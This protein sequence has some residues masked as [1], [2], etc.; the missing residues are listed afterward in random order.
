MKTKR[1]SKWKSATLVALALALMP[2]SVHG[3]SQ[4][5]TVE[6]PEST[7]RT[8]TKTIQLPDKA[9]VEEMVSDNGAVSYTVNGKDATITV[10]GGSP[11]SNQYNATKYARTETTSRTS[12]TNSFPSS[13]SYNS[14][15]F[16][17]SLYP[18]GNSYQI[19]GSFTQADTIY[20][21][22]QTSSYYNSGGY[23]GT[24]SQYLYSGSYTPSDSKTVTNGASS[25]TYGDVCYPGGVLIYKSPTSLAGSKYYSSGGY[26]GTLYLN[27]WSGVHP[28]P[29]IACGVSPNITYGYRYKVDY[30]YSGTV[31]KPGSDT[32]VYRYRG[33]VTRPASDTRQYQQDYSG[34]VY[35]A[36]YDTTYRYS[37]NVNYDVD[38][39]APDAVITQTP[40]TWTNGAVTIQL[41]NIQDD[42]YSGLKHVV[43]P[44]G[45]IMNQ[46]SIAYAVTT[47]GNYDFIL[48]DNLGN[49]RTKTVSV[50]NIEKVAPTANLS[51][52]TTDWTNSNVTLNLTAI[53]DS[54]GSGYS[55]TK[56]PNGSYVTTTT[57]S[58]VV[59][60]N[61]T[62]SFVIY[63]NAGNSTTKSITVSNI[64]KTPPSGT[65]QNDSSEPLKGLLLTLITDNTGSGTDTIKKPDGTI[66]TAINASVRTSSAGEYV[67]EITDRAGNK[68]VVKSV[69]KT[70]TFSVTQDGLKYVIDVQKQYNEV[71][72]IQRIET[73]ESFV[74]ENKSYP[75]TG[76]GD[77]T[78][79][80]NDGGIW[81]ESIKQTISKYH[82]LKA[83]RVTVTYIEDWTNDDIL[84][85]VKV[86]SLAGNKIQWVELP[87]GQRTTDTTF[88]YLVSKN[89]IY[90]FIA[91][92]SEGEYGYGS[93]VINQIDTITPVIQFKTPTEWV[94][95]DQT[96]S[97]DIINE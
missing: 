60:T 32:T 36:G 47:N 66:V 97:V 43:L 68:S 96:I 58:Q 71:P 90:P 46:T 61:G 69:V 34:T 20:V 59:T 94:N 27:T 81:S 78:F 91:M 75:I 93:A 42:G 7:S 67:F 10:S 41:S 73:G 80:V 40:L 54:G 28:D 64:D 92:D 33:Y 53:A 16:S 87:G 15:G 85:N 39:I 8:M 2:I 74:S 89:G 12:S 22:G 19:S 77:Y 63:D 26:T 52:S 82:E 70:P 35:G 51:A 30:N 49:Q 65:I 17:G 83:P 13:I 18:N 3:A 88:T 11:Y 79:R 55:K 38:N 5:L 45:V 84:V 56:L 37:V 14:G 50:T 95:T 25:Y 44:N 6:F 21:T 86:D 4:Q 9:R 76:N 72:I 24:L 29:V 1:Q 62:Y 23:S 48:E 57:A 31:T